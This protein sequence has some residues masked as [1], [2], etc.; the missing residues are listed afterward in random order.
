MFIVKIVSKNNVQTLLCLSLL[1][2]PKVHGRHDVPGQRLSHPGIRQPLDLR[3]PRLLLAPSEG[4]R[5]LANRVGRLC[6]AD[7]RNRFGHN[8][9]LR[10]RWSQEHLAGHCVPGGRIYL[11]HSGCLP[12]RLH[13]PGCSRLSRFRFLSFAV[14]HLR[15]V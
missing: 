13:L 3:R 9:H 5:E 14:V 11:L 8:G 15:E 1:Q 2:N 10:D 12:C 4:A 7:H 6:P